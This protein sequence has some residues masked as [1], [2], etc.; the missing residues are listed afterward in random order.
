M[1]H[2]HD[3][4]HLDKRD[5]VEVVLVVENFSELRASRSSDKTV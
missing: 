3:E 2:D 4:N 5:D 1:V